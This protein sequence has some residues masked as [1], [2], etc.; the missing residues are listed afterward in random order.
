LITADDA[1]ASVEVIETADQALRQQ[2][3]VRIAAKRK[4]SVNTARADGQ[5]AM[6]AEAAGS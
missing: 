4:G 2:N 3:W 1:L 6:Q 5:V